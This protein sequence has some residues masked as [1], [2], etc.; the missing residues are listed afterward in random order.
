MSFFE[1]AMMVCFGISWP[2][3]IAKSVRTQDVRGKS[4]LFMSVVLI[5]YACGFIH[6]VLH[7]LDWVTILYVLNFT[8]VAIDI[9]LYFKYLPKKQ[10]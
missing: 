6:K 4:S 7:S 9:C 8:F 2:I 3:S 5:G 10:D 1:A